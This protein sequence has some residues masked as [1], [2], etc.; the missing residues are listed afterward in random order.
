MRGRIGG[1]NIHREDDSNSPSEEDI[2]G[3]ERLSASA[4]VFFVR[5]PHFHEKSGIEE[6][7]GEERRAIG[8]SD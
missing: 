5:Y 7:R 1:A 4:A 3:L 6:S 2:N 8:L